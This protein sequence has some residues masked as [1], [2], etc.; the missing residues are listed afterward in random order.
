M[1]Q[2]A[3]INDGNGCSLELWIVMQHHYVFVNV[4]PNSAT[5]KGSDKYNILFL[6]TGKSPS[7]GPSWLFDCAS[8][9][10]GH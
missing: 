5:Q 4:P 2:T 8:H 10:G 6:K 9:V 7:E 3:E 1:K